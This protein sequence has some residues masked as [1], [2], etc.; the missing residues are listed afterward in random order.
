MQAPA[1][2]GPAQN[3]AGHGAAVL[4]DAAEAPGVQVLPA[5]NAAALQ[6]AA[7]APG[8]VGAAE[9][10]TAQALISAPGFLRNGL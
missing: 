6:Y 1:T 3:K 7:P 4:G 8:S 9:V 5:P 10:R 2:L